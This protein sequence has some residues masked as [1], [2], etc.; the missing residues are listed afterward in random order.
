MAISTVWDAYQRKIK[1][2]ITFASYAPGRLT[3][4]TKICRRSISVDF[5]YPGGTLNRKKVE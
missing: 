2:F 5:D 4:Q 1:Q 3:H